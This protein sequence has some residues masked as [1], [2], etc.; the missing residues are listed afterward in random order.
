MT[1]RRR[2]IRAHVSLTRLTRSATVLAVGAA[3]SVA[4]APSASSTTMSA[5]G[6]A[7]AMSA[8]GPASTMSAGG[9]ASTMSAG[10]PASRPVIATAAAGVTSAASSRSGAAPATGGAPSAATGS[11]AQPSGAKLALKDAPSTAP[12]QAGASLLP[13]PKDSNTPALAGVGGRLADPRGAQLLGLTWGGAAP[14]RMELR[15][16]DRSGTWSPWAVLDDAG[17]TAQAPTGKGGSTEAIWV[18]DATS[19]EVRAVRAGVD[20]TR[21]LTL[22]LVTSPRSTS[23]AA[24]S[25]APQ[26]VTED[27]RIAMV[28]PPITMYNRAAWGAD[29]TWRAQDTPT[30]SDE[31]RAAVVHHTASTN[32][33]APEDVPAQ[34]RSF[35]YYHT[36]VQGWRDIGY[37]ALVDQW[38]RLWEGRYGGADLNLM[39]AQALGFNWRTL[40]ISMIGTHSTV[41]PSPAELETVSQWIA[42]RF[43]LAGIGDP[44]SST[45]LTS[46]DDGTRWPSGTVVTVP[47][48]FGHRQVNLTDC[49]GDAGA[50]AVPGIRARVGQL[51]SVDGGSPAVL[52]LTS[53]AMRTSMRGAARVVMQSDGNLVVTR[54]DGS[55]AFSSKTNVPGSTLAVVAEGGIMVLDPKGRPIWTA[56]VQAPGGLLRIQDDANLVLYSA[57]GRP[58]WDSMGA[59]GNK[60]VSYA[61]TDLVWQLGPGSSTRSAR[62]THTVSMSTGG[63]LEIR[64]ADGTRIWGNKGPV[65]GSELNQQPDGN[66]VVRDPAGEVLWTTATYAPW[67]FLRIQDDGNLVLYSAGRQPLWDS[68]G[69]TRH[70]AVSYVPRVNVTRLDPGTSVTTPLG[71]YRLDMAGS[72]S[73]TV[74]DVHNVQVWTSGSTTADSYLVMQPDGNL[75]VYSATGKPRWAAMVY[76]PGA[77]A[78]LQEDGNLVVYSTTGTAVWDSKGFLGKAG[79]LFP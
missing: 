34:I 10:G 14:D 27:P 8:G 54:A 68:M 72:G 79:V 25:L 35:Y 38:G 11:T 45:Q 67:G 15:S 17:R 24:Y 48:I 77:R 31:L 42:W 74:T 26:T 32:S 5:G 2:V 57:E 64:K 28:A 21:E 47:R 63:E 44:S 58:L 60:G 49:P 71:G 66:A 39:G 51:L 37:N 16:R 29:E 56:G 55:T 65:P 52:G 73:A 46:R 13:T 19:V 33:Y 36:K 6:P 30:Y 41:A 40:G 7:S 50:A 23:D 62:G 12:Q 78:L 59:L 76:S 1:Y 69:Y 18:G 43:R 70:P 20:V 75:V 9:P 22:N 53:G 3:L 4:G 61:A